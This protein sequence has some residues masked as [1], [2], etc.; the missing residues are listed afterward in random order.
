MRTALSRFGSTAIFLVLFAGVAIFQ[1][2]ADRFASVLPY[3]P[4]ETLSPQALR[5]LD[6]G[7][8]NA[9]GSLLWLDLIQQIGGGQHDTFDG[10][11]DRIAAINDLYPTFAYPYAF[12]VLMVPGI[13]PSE[14]EKAIAIGKRGVEL[15]LPDWRIPYYLA[16]AL[17]LVLKDPE[18]AAPYFA[19][20]AQ[21]P[22]TPEGVK[23][24]ALRYGSMKDPMEQSRE[25]WASLYESSKDDVVRDRALHNVAHFDILIGLRNAIAV[26]EKQKGAAPSSIQDLI[27][28]RIIKGVP[29][30]PIG[31]TYS[32]GENGALVMTKVKAGYW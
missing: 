31:I 5:V 9:M 15:K 16:M 13:E 19:V 21:M 1:V 14:T 6:L 24:T 7:M 26:Y 27:D 2:G 32:I 17:H 10:I 12:E 30:D 8:H 11:S 22:D 3:G 28:A 18:Q 25:L 23:K 29:E 20:T 4:I